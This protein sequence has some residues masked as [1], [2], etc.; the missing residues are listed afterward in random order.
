MIPQKQKVVDKG[1]GDCLRACIASI[2][3][4]PNDDRLPN[5]H[6]STWYSTWQKWFGQFGLSM[7]YDDQRI[8]RE[9]YWIA[10]V[11]SKNYNDGTTHAIVMKGQEVAFDPSTKKRYRTGRQMLG[12]NL[13]MGG[14][15]FEVIDPSLLYKFE[16][17]KKGA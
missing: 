8:W 7:E 14:W 11:K 15:W 3:E 6:G 1:R 9:S 12:G 5:I 2:L 4:L 10:S 13:V 17:Y 16:E